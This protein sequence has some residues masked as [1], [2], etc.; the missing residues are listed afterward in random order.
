MHLLNGELMKLS[1]L[2]RPIRVSKKVDGEKKLTSLIWLVLLFISKIGEHMTLAGAP[3]SM[4]TWGDCTVV[5][6]L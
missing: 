3:V 1:T 2:I 4:R 6:G 5:K